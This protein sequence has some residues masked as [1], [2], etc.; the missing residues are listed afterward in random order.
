MMKIAAF[1]DFHAHMWKEFD[2]KGGVTGSIRLDN[3]INTLSYMREWCKTNGVTT[4]LFAGD[5]FHQRGR[6]DTVVFNA[7]YDE[8]ERFTRDNISIIMIAG[9]HDQYD[10][11]DIP[12]NSLHSFKK[13]H[14]VHVYDTVGTRLVVRSTGYGEIVEEVEIV[15]APYS[16]N[17]QMIKDYIAGV[18]KKDIPQILLFH[19][20]VSGAFVGNGNY[21]MADAFSVEDLRPDLFKYIIGGHFHKR[22]H[23][24]GHP[25]AFYCGAPVQ[26]SFGDEG[27][28][29]G[30]YVVDT[31]KRWDIEFIPIPNPYFITLEEKV[32]ADL[33]D[34]EEFLNTCAEEGNYVRFIATPELLAKWEEII[35]EGL[36]YKV[37]LRKEYE[38]QERSEVKVG[39]GFE[40]IVAKYADENRPDAKEIGLELIREALAE[41]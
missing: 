36:K 14:G 29:K 35:P 16:K 25:N 37:E 24:G 20:G 21:P 39:M 12:E 6:V 23:L 38:Q 41:S 40:E 18:E 13:L 17:A 30:F 22:Q 2:E 34:Y 5:L 10:N 27:E 32:G 4:L 8:I 28:T 9:N 1:A 7:V 33:T 15:C 26:H 3:Q 11:S 31:S 19:L